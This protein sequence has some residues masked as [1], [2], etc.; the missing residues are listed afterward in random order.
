MLR[1][2]LPACGVPSKAR[3]IQW[4]VVKK[5]VLPILSK[6]AVDTKE[7]E[8]QRRLLKIESELAKLATMPS[9]EDGIVE[10]DVGEM[11]DATVN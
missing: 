8:Y 11:R 1:M 4:G 9:N 3:G 6:A 5:E 10:G 2:F 7:Q